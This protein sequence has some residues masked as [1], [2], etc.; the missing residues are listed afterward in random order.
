MNEE[1]QKKLNHE[2][3]DLNFKLILKELEKF[4]RD[5]IK[6]QSQLYFFISE[7][8]S[9]SSKLIE[10]FDFKNSF[11]IFRKIEKLIE[12]LIE[13]LIIFD[14]KLFPIKKI[15][16]EINKQ[17]SI[18]DNHDNINFNYNT[19]EKIEHYFNNNYNFFLEKLVRYYIIICNNIGNIYLIREKYFSAFKYLAKCFSV[20]KT[21]MMNSKLSNYHM[22]I[23]LFNL[24]YS[25]NLLEEKIKSEIFIIEALKIFELFKNEKN[26][27]LIKNERSSDF[28]CIL[29]YIFN[30]SYLFI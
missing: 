28:L 14:T 4:Q 12:I 8:F 9:H 24:S 5:P 3:L 19:N 1:I 30:F 13:S 6:L 21:I 22:G 17:Y 18:N 16:K 11:Y 25:Y 26:Q 20:R 27:E 2:S 23:I 10:K 29:E 15:L 7:N